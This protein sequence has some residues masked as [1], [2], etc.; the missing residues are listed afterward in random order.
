MRAPCHT[1]YLTRCLE[2]NVSRNCQTFAVKIK[3]ETQTKR[4]LDNLN[5]SAHSTTALI[6]LVSLHSTVSL[7]MFRF[8]DSQTT[9]RSFCLFVFLNNGGADTQ[10]PSHHSPLYFCVTGTDCFL[11][12]CFFFGLHDTREK[13]YL[14]VQ[15]LT[16]VCPCCC[17]RRRPSA[18]VAG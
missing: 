17:C 16:N 5:P 18:T 11:F 12:F 4:N 13:R 1:S 7:F 3:E 14:C 10:L 15:I 6:P 9:S 2:A 8:R